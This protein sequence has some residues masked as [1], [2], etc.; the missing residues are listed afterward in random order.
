[1]W[2]AAKAC[3]SHGAIMIVQAANTG[4]TGGSTPYGEYD[5]PVV[6]ISTTRIAAILP[7]REGRE[8][9]CL[10][11]STLT[12]LEQAI[13]PLGRVPHSV[14]G[15]SC[16]GAS[17]VG[18]ICNNSGGA[19]VRR[20]PAFTRHSLFGRI[21]SG[22][23]LQLHN[24]LGRD[25]GKTPEAILGA[26]DRGDTGVEERQSLGDAT[27]DGI[28]PIDYAEHVRQ[29][30]P[31]PA[32]F[33]ADPAQL[34][35]AAGCAGKLVVF[36]VKVPTFPAP[37]RERSF[38]VGTN[39]PEQLALL[40]RTMLDRLDPL[41]S[42]CEYMHRSASDLAASHGRD[43]CQTLALFGP[44]AMPRVLNLQKRVDVVGRRVGLGD[45]LA[46]RVSQKLSQL[47]G[48]PAPASV[49]R[50]VR[51]HEHVL[52]ITADDGGIERLED[53]LETS[54]SIPGLSFLP[55]SKKE[56]DAA[57]RLRFASAGATVRLRDLSSGS[58]ELAALDI[59]LPRDTTDWL[60]RLPEELESQVLDRAIY[61]HFLCHVFHLDY[62]L[63]PGFRA[64]TF[65]EGVKALVET[66]GG[67]M[68]AEHNFGHLY[69]APHHVAQFYR[70]LD[71]TNSLNPGIGRTSRQ[72]NW[73][74]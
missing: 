36:A 64:A 1:M 22:G 15:S 61:G 71:P 48:H 8:A 63:K 74:E 4:L 17:V 10:A 26:L 30:A 27:R 9:I 25:L 20:G 5:R 57:F 65:E 18:G 6:L 33:N 68:P 2:D 73:A 12:G 59:A 41:P 39:S 45:H 29:K 70:Q 51:A 50:F 69:K 40:R 62:V 19:L 56:A 23:E 11:G 13:R 38:I 55:M 49:Q 72:L 58:C 3:N 34:H 28:E 7:L 31:T 14:I 21:T 16:I 32:R 53:L 43:I 54:F 60:L 66:R 67:Q 44:S 52:L 46:G 35:D 47:G 42:V 37:A 24:E